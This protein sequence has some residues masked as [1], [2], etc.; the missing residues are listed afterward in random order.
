MITML[1]FIILLFLLP[2]SWTYIPPKITVRRLSDQPIISFWSNQS[3]FRFNYNS[4][5]LPLPDGSIAL[6]VR[7]Q[8]LLPN[9][10]S[11]Y[12]VGPSKLAIVKQ[13]D[14][15]LTDYEYVHNAQIIIDSEDRPYQIAGVEDPRIT[16]I[17]GSYYL[18]YTAVYWTSSHEWSAHAALA[19]CDSGKDPTK[20]GNWILHPPLFPELSWSKAATLLV[21]NATHQYVFFNESNIE[22]A[23][24]VNNDLCHYRYRNETFIHIRSDYFDSELVEP[25]P[26]PQRLSDGNYLFLYNSARRLPLPNNH[27]KPNWDREYNLGWVI[28][29]GKDP[30]NILARSDQPILVPELDWE[31]C[32]LE[33]GEWAKRGLT[34]RVIF[35]EGW[36]QTSTDRFLLW[37]QGCDAVTGLAEVIIEF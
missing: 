18:F 35:A 9:A 28:M 7:V 13:V 16:I 20:K 11:N 29:D 3:Q 14:K 8:D 22:L 6:V 32:D 17:N 26:E 34:P 10:T 1:C 36:K 2:I 4:A 37:Y 31:R 12:D 19:I 30:T 15:S 21:H 25:G 24:A 27:L 5:F 33:S 23:L